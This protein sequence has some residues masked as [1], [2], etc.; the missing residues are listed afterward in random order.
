MQTDQKDSRSLGKRTMAI[1]IVTA[2]TTFVSETVRTVCA[3]HG[4]HSPLRRKYLHIDDNR[5]LARSGW[6]ERSLVQRALPDAALCTVCRRIAE[7]TLG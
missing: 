3:L 2:K 5:T 6:Y 1:V 4:R 7:G